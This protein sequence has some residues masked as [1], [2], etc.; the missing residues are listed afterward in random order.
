MRDAPSLTGL[1][2]QAGNGDKPAWDALVDRY[3]PLIWAICQRHHLSRA[4][5]LDAGQAVWLQAA[6]QLA[7]VR[8][9]AAL[10]GWLATTTQRECLRVL[11]A[12]RRPQARGQVLDTANIADEQTVMQQ[13]LV[14]A[15]RNAALREAFTHLPPR[16]QQL[17]IMLTQDPPVPYA[18]ISA[19]LG[20]PVENIAP[21]R[22]RCLAK[23]SHDP[24]I[25]ALIN[26]E[27]GTAR[28]DIPGRQWFSD[29]NQ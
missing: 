15:E 16:C 26:G 24:A 20:I 22:V 5:A 23:L 10:A 19:R 11:H 13:E 8:D 14:L 27:A 21:S 25:A 6:G 29:D 1:V 7:T 18:E 4:D 28:S 3:A 17:I 2:T 12:A 9:P